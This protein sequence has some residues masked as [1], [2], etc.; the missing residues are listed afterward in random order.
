[1]GGCSAE[2]AAGP[3]AGRDL[4]KSVLA[5]WVPYQGLGML[6]GTPNLWEQLHGFWTSMR[7]WEGE[8][9]GWGEHERRNI[10]LELA[11]PADEVLG[12]QAEKGS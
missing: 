7:K 3:P 9:G 5:S 10:H 2:S 1:M 11:Q 8:G 4:F 6:R 12:A